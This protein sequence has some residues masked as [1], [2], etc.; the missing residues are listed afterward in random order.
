[1]QGVRDMGTFSKSRP[2]SFFFFFGSVLYYYLLN[3]S[4]RRISHMKQTSIIVL[5]LAGER[6]SARNERS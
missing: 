3:E 1:M 2:K 5:N 4:K 6:G